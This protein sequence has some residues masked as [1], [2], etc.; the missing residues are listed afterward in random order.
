MLVLLSDTLVTEMLASGRVKTFNLWVGGLRLLILPLEYI[1]LSLF[2]IPYM[3]VGVQIF[4][5]IVSLLVRLRCLENVTGRNHITP[6]MKSV[7]APISLVTIISV[8]LSLTLN[9][10]IPDNFIGLCLFSA[11][12]MIACIASIYFLGITASERSTIQSAAVNRLRKIGIIR[13]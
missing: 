6:F 10:H 12:T 5:E 1:V 4:M 13:T 2:H 11:L 9:S 8:G 3:V 7:A